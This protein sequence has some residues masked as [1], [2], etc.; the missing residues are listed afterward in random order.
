MQLKVPKNSDKYFWT[1]HAVFK[2]RQYGLSE[3]KIRHVI[4]SPFRKEEGIVK[5]TVAVM[6]PV[7]V[8][9]ILGKPVWKQEIWTMYQIKVKSLKSHAYRQAG[10]VESEIS[11]EPKTKNQKPVKI[12]SAWR[13][14]GVSPKKNPI[15]EDILTEI[16]SLI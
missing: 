9:N 12:I 1:A 5:N 2:M 10:K 4:K 7:S 3:Q 11:Y 8:K 14:P 16:G 6:Q 15:P 13:Y